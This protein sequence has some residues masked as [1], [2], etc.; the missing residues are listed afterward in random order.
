MAVITALLSYLARQV[1]TILQAVFGWSVSALFGKLPR[2]SELFIIAAL[3]LS[4]AWPIFVVGAFVPAV[5][6]WAIAMVPL[7]NWIGGGVLRAIWITL[8]VLAPIVVGLLVRAATPLRE[9]R[10]LTAMLHGYPVALGFFVAFVITVITV[11]LLKAASIVRGWSDEHVYV[12]PHDG[13]YQAV[14]HALAEACARAGLVP[15]ISD[16]PRHLVAATTVMRRLARGAVASLI[17]EQLQR[18]TAEGLQIY[19]YPADLVLRG[20]PHR[21]ARVRAMIGR[22]QIDTHA[23]LVA[24]SAAKEAQDELARLNRLLA[25]RRE[26]GPQ[27][28]T[29]LAVRLREIYVKLMRTDLS[30]AEWTILEAMARR[31]ERRLVAAG[32]IAAGASP[33]DEQPD[34]MQDVA[35]RLNR[36]EVTTMPNPTSPEPET[37]DRQSMAELVGRTL[38]DAKQL[39]RAEL[40]LAKQDLRAEVKSAT[41]AAI[42]FAVA[43]A[44]AWLVIASLV[45]MVC[46]ATGSA[47]L[48]L[49]FAILFLVAGATFAML[50]WKTLPKKPLDPTRKR[51]E[52]DM[53][54]LKEHLA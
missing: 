4:L 50:G 38:E 16:V 3:L 51:V 27:P 28:G 42:D 36:D 18:I 25:E 29:I 39:A 9:R 1:S 12:Q 44:S 2:R 10:I 26:H 47:L 53:D 19:L 46:L 13:E 31:C 40:E 32:V 35:R 54:K 49:G 15:E 43:F 37:Q 11:P 21:V 33:I 23:Y 14:L 17:S 5:A 41:R 22:T 7:H 8:A 48:A 6:S 20:D 30:F 52:S 34:H 45:L 24:S